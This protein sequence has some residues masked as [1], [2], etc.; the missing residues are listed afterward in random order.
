MVRAAIS[1][2]FPL[3]QMGVTLVV[4]LALIAACVRLAAY[5]LQFEDV[6]L[7]SYGGSLNKFFKERVL[8]RQPAKA[9]RSAKP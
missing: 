9:E 4:S 5:I 2:T 3:L 6:M 1:G 8:R 7:G